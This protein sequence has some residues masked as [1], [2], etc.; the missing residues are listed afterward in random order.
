MVI[1]PSPSE[2]T[3]TCPASPRRRASPEVVPAPACGQPPYGA[4]MDFLLR[5]ARIVELDGRAGLGRARRR[6]GGGRPRPR[7]RPRPAPAARDPGGR[8]R[9]ALA[10]PRAVGPAHPPEDVDGH[11][12]PA[13][14]RRH[15]VGG[16]G[17][18]PAARPAGGRARGAG[19][20][21][22]PPPGHLA[23][24]AQRRGPGRGRRRTCRWCSSAATPPRLAELPRARV[25]GL[26]PSRGVLAEAEWY[27]VYPRVAEIAGDEARP[28]PTSA[29]SAPPPRSGV[30]GVVELEYGEKRRRLGRPAGRRG[31]TC[32]GSA[33]ATTP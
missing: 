3:R 8:R 29:W 31:S 2:A 25:L 33:A 13:R 4:R 18:V 19:R 24:A 15:P 6:A 30:M 23:G 10:G 9:R 11:V 1:V 21:L 22:R 32:S 28:R 20:R 14:P 17:A 7:H 5:R 16:R 12:R 27:T 26:A